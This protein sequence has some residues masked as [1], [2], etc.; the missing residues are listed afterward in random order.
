M[1]KPLSLSKIIKRF[2]TTWQELPDHRH[3]SNNTCYRIADAAASAFSVFFMQSPSFLAHQRDMHQH[4]GRDNV[5]TLFGVENIPSDNQIR[6]LLDPIT[7]DHFHADFAWVIEEL[8]RSGQ[9]ASFQAYAGTYLIAFDGVVFHSSEKIHCENCTTR[10][11]RSGVTH[12]YHSAIIPVMVKPVSAH[13]LSLPPECI[14]PQDGHEKQDCERAAVKRWLAHHQPRYQPHTVTYLGDDL[15]ANQPL[16]QLIDQTYAQ[17]FVFVCKPDSHRTLYEWLASLEGAD[18]LETRQDRH[19]N[20]KHGEI[21]SYRLVNQV[22]LRAGDDP[23]MVNWFELTITHEE[24][25][26]V[27]YHNAWV[28]NHLLSPENV[29]QL[30]VVGRARWKVE[31]ENIN[32]LKT[33]GYNLNHN[34]GHGEAHLANVFFTLNLL[35]FL[36]H[37]TQHLVNEA[38]R[39]LRETLSVRRTFF[40]DLKA[41]TRYM[42]FASWESLFAFMIE[43]LELDLPPP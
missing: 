28:T 7:P 21:W 15:Y 14:V 12:Y 19:W 32:V 43:G 40:N 4:K 3:P 20:G 11:D 5:A 8:E 30:A 29:S 1:S 33:K 24:T 35:A 42:V 31:N 13:V 9:L 22:P 10:Q 26:K 39:L 27:I 23:M 16:C 6:N 25:G 2:Q 38:Y 37:T 18:G 17:F 36:V 34:F 41:L